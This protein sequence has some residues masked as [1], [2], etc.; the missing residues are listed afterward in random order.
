[1]HAPTTAHVIG[2]RCSFLFMS[3]LDITINAVGVSCYI[4]VTL[5][6]TLMHFDTSKITIHS[7][8]VVLGMHSLCSGL[9]WCV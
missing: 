1:M 2:L 5:H 3:T 9:K 7:E 4:I 6:G 8:V